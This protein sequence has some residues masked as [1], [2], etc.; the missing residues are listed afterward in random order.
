MSM[1]LISSLMLY[2]LH[3]MRFAFFLYQC[4]TGKYV[5]I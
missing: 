3:F 5:L 1:T 2:K 4:V